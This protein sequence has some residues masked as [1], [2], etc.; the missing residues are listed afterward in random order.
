MLFNWISRDYSAQHSFVFFKFSYFIFGPSQ[1]HLPHYFCWFIPLIVYFESFYCPT[2]RSWLKYI[3]RFIAHSPDIQLERNMNGT[4]RDS[5][6]RR[7]IWKICE[8]IVFASALAVLCLPVE[9]WRFLLNREFQC[10]LGISFVKHIYK[11]YA[12]G[13]GFFPESFFSNNR[14][15][16]ELIKRRNERRVFSEQVSFVFA[17]S[18]NATMLLAFWNWILMI[19]IFLQ[20]WHPWCT[21][22]NTV[23]LAWRRSAGRPGNIPDTSGTSRADNYSSYGKILM[24]DY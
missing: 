20:L 11:L 10:A 8:R 24:G 19:I 1:N 15:N 7:N 3:V 6:K 12:G 14:W 5:L 18:V 21:C 13:R 9:R 16:N 2:H 4:G 23:A 17:I 22:W